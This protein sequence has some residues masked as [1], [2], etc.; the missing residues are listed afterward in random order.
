MKRILLIT[1]VITSIANSLKAQRVTYN[2]MNYALNHNIEN[3]ET[4]L[5]KKGFSY[6]GIDTLNDSTKEYSYSFTKNS[7]ESPNYI[8]VSK[9]TYNNVF[10]ESGLYTT[11]Q[12]DYLKIKLFI[13][14]IGYKLVSTKTTDIGGVIFVYKL[15]DKEIDFMV[16]RKADREITDYYI[17]LTDTKLEQSEFDNLHN[18]K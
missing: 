2:D 10:I 13:K 1:I 11:K 15:R 18:Q 17:T 16:T 6:G 4:Y 9:K 12:D 5:S 8:S 7:Y 14:S 3:T